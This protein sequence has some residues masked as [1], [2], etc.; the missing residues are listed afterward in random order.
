MM[1]IQ[2]EVLQREKKNDSRIHGYSYDTYDSIYLFCSWDVGT[3][4]R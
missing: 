3:G 2:R 4:S 1:I